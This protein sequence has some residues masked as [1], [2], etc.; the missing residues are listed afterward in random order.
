[1]IGRIFISL[2]QELRPLNMHS[3]APLDVVKAFHAVLLLSSGHIRS[4]AVKLRS[5]LQDL[6]HTAC[7]HELAAPGWGHPCF[8]L[9]Y[10]K[11]PM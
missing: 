10:D 4:D 7:S 8:V 2:L 5:T 9:S 1:V 11:S 3:Y 6:T